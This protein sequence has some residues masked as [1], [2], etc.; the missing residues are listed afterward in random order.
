MSHSEQQ[1]WFK[2]KKFG[3]GWR[4]ATWQ[5]WCLVAFYV[6]IVISSA[7]V[8]LGGAKSDANKFV[9]IV[10][11]ALIFLSATCLLIGVSLLKGEAPKVGKGD[12]ND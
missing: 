2:A 10:A 8:L 5:A 3:W 7:V 6:A 9:G 4:P 12:K 1:Y 11:F